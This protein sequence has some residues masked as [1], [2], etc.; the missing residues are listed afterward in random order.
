VCVLQTLFDG[1]RNAR[2][3]DV[4]SV[5]LSQIISIGVVH[6]ERVCRVAATV[7][8]TSVVSIDSFTLNNII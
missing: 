3:D 1:L 5:V 6:G 4:I 2:T 7:Y 8:T